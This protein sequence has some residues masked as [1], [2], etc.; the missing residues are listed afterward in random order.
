VEHDVHTSDEN[1]DENKNDNGVEHDVHTSD[2]NVDE[3][4]NDN[5]VVM[6]HDHVSSLAATAVVFGPNDM[7]ESSMKLPVGENYVVDSALAWTTLTLEKL[8]N[9]FGRSSN[10]MMSKRYAEEQ[11]QVLNAF[12]SKSDKPSYSEKQAVAFAAD[13]TVLQVSTW[14]NN[15][16][17]RLV[18]H[19]RLIEQKKAQSDRRA[20]LQR[21]KF[22]N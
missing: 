13:M 18:A 12:F 22:C 3:N 17:K 10:I 4:K 6:S 21:K 11:T 15:R 1:V 2:E 20:G 9:T 16:R 19:R 5:G 14:F 8:T 7:N